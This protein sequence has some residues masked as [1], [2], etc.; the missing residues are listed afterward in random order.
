MTPRTNPGD[1]EMAA[2]AD[3]AALSQRRRNVSRDDYVAVMLRLA[4]EGHVPADVSLDDLLPHMPVEVTRGSFYFHFGTMGELYS[5]VLARWRAETG[6]AAIETMRDSAMRVVR[7]QPLQRLELLRAWARGTAA[8]DRAIRRWADRADGAGKAPPR[9]ARAA[10]AEAARAA[11]AEEAKAAVDAADA[12]I[13]GD[14]HRALR[15]IGY[16]DDVAQVLALLLIGAFTS[17]SISDERFER[18]LRFLRSAAPRRAGKDVAVADAGDSVVLYGADADDQD[19]AELAQQF[20]AG[21][22]RQGSP[23]QGRPARR[24]AAPSG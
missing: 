11:A 14:I 2:A 4:A 21:H 24:K 6:S 13:I 15:D 5:A 20:A 1:R 19:S 23:G 12:A 18:L 10:A 16:G 7:D 8:R 9:G 22:S 17:D 3:G